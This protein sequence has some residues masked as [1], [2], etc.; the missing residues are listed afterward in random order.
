MEEQVPRAALRS[1]SSEPPDIYPSS[2]MDLYN[3]ISLDYGTQNVGGVMGE[4]G[5]LKV[6][7]HQ[8]AMASMVRVHG[9]V[10]VGERNPV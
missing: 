7:T 5:N 2:I 4:E 8:D 6:D 9:G 10:G 1:T 3:D